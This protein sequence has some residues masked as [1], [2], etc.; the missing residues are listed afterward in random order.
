MAYA[1]E[2][3]HV[4]KQYGGVWQSKP[5][6]A[7]K[8]FNLQ[9]EHGEIFGFLGPNGA[10]KTTAIHIA[11]GFVR[12]TSGAGRMLGESFGHAPTRRRVGFL[13]EN[14]TFYHLSAR[15]LIRTYG[16]LN[17]MRDPRLRERVREML[18]VF[19]LE[20]AADRSV[21]KFSRGML[22]RVGLAQALVNDPDLLVLD[23]PTSAL[24]PVV[25]VAV[26][27]L[28]LKAREKG[29]TVF[30]S[31]H[32]LSEIEMICDRVAILHHGSVVRLGKT[33]ELLE[34]SDQCEVVVQ[35]VKNEV[36]PEAVARDGRLH[37]LAP[38]SMQRNII[39]RA[40]AAGGEVVSVNPVRKSLE[41]VFLELAKSDANEKNHKEGA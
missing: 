2:Y 11:L 21:G 9:V 13:A 31:S 17:G 7:L 36:F 15:N 32:L 8:D 20:E 35:R 3:D 1:L 27:E 5:V 34:S 41:T 40:W 10:G 28:L 26:R 14:P 22:Q 29:K 16:A 23:E 6:H 4:S 12:P 19:D 39:E 30:I 37:L 25:R 18:K 24:D 38:L 33:S